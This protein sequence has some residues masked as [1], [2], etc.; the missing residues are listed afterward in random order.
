MPLLFLAGLIL[1]L[2]SF[3][4]L[5]SGGYLAWSWFEGEV[6]RNAD[7]TLQRVRE[8]WRLW[9]ALV[10]LGWS[11]LGRFII[12][13]LLARPDT[14]RT[15]PE[16]GEGRMI[17]GAGGA[18]FYV[19]THGDAAAP[20]LVL[21]HGWGM[22]STIWYYARKHLAEQFR[23]IVWDLPGLGRSKAK[24]PGAVDLARFAA[25][26][27]SV[28]GLAGGQPVVLVGHS[29]GGMTIQTLARD[30]AAFFNREVAGAVLLNTTYTNPLETMILSRL[31]KALRWP[32][33]EPAMRLAI[34]LQ[35]LAWLAAWQSYFSGSAHIA[36]RL[37]FGRFVT[38]SQLNHTTLLA[39]RNPPGVLARG[40]LAMF[41]WDATR[42][43]TTVAT[44]ILVIGGDTDIVTK[45]EASKVIAADAP[46]ARL[47]V[48]EGV[49]H[50]GFLEQ[51]GIYNE[52]IAAFAASV[53]PASEAI[54]V[55]A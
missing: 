36:N 6:I 55:P 52:A 12:P 19:E 3:A 4:L 21:I 25:D 47:Q 48:I 16:R 33:L 38:R 30:D 43:L 41:R 54:P 32:L 17:E 50:M 13:L 34:W 10:L 53:Q 9:M 45:L 37:G 2:F 29:I 14:D 28:I 24:G 26:L 51:A 11:F 49:N 42:A 39:T 1:G 20:P 46:K 35:P 18:S 27:K 31:V 15:R 22:D 8:D 44:P 7:G 23:V 5:G 40:N